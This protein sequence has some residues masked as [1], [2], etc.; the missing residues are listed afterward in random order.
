M[1]E[2]GMDGYD[3][4][5]LDA[6]QHDGSLTNA[7]LGER[8]HLSASQCSRRR[9][10]LEKAGLIR[11][12]AARLDAQKLGLGLRAI[13]RVNLRAH[14][15]G[16]ED[17]FTRFLRAHPQVH[18]AFSVSGD[19]DYVLDIRVRDLEAF[20]AFVH[21]DLLPHPQVAQV[22][23]EIVLKTMKDGQALDLGRG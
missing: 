5:I 22:R 17:D 4:A 21:Q 14:G 12:Y 10:A 23:S 2:T 19:A 9:A 1:R 13:T 6:L 3:L 18:A 11:G 8:V 15:Q 7:A 16:H 20:A